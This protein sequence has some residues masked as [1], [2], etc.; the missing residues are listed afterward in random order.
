MPT[1]EVGDA[2]RVRPDLQAVTF[3]YWN[4][5]CHEPGG[6]GYLRGLRLRALAEVLA[7][8][9]ADVTDEQLM[10]A[11]DLGWQEFTEAWHANRQFSAFD[12]AELMCDAL[13]QVAAPGGALRSKLVDAYCTATEGCDLV[14][15]DGVEVVLRALRQRGVRIGIVCDVG[16]T[17]SPVLR[18]VLDE[19]GLLELF[20]HW[21]FSDEVGVYKPDPR[22][23]HHALEG[24][25]GVAPG[26]AAHVGDRRRTD[27]AGALGVGM[28][29][30]RFTAVFDDDDEAQGP[31]GDVVVA[32]YAEFLPALGLA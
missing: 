2:F 27:V 13:G 4:T 31:S 28:T 18:R 23:F 32:S 19:R 26:V 30:V 20:D 9:G 8:A 16:L 15:I 10:A 11:S 29:A 17:P 21:S 5:L 25:G 6:I 3:D 22:I 1:R 12:A 14:V 7:S 24:L